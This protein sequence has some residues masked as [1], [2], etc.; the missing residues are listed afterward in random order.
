MRGAKN[1][2]I[3]YFIQPVVFTRNELNNRL[4]LQ[5][6]FILE[7]IGKGKVLCG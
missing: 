2:F 4:K 7:I 3:I 5:D 6:N 1:S